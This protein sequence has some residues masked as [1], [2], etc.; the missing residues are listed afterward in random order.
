M[1]KKRTEESNNLKRSLFHPERRLTIYKWSLLC[2]HHE[3]TMR[4]DSSSINP[5]EEK[6]IK[7]AVFGITTDMSGFTKKA[8]PF[9]V[10]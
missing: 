2:Q 6:P 4:T 5:L 1:N 9:S 7:A 10:Y 8:Y 3:T